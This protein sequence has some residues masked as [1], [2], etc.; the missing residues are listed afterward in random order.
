MVV[1][2]QHLSLPLK[3]LYCE[4]VVKVWAELEECAPGSALVCSR[5]FEQRWPKFVKLFPIVSQE[6]LRSNSVAKFYCAAKFWLYKFYCAAKFWLYIYATPWLGSLCPKEVWPQSF[7]VFILVYEV[8]SKPLNC[9]DSVRYWEVPKSPLSV[10]WL[11]KDRRN[12]YPFDQ[13]WIQLS[14]I[15]HNWLKWPNIIFGYPFGHFWVLNRLD[16]ILIVNRG[17]WCRSRWARMKWSEAAEV[18][19][20]TQPAYFAGGAARYWGYRK[21]F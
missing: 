11:L 9:Y 8:R 4:P 18:L 12:G 3:T 13:S 6:Q 17:A 2:I 5:F 15:D 10:S 19:W 14:I 20:V 7:A 16:G 21:W 1:A